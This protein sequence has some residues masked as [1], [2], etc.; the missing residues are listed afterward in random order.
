[1]TTKELDNLITFKMGLPSLYH[2]MLGMS[3]DETA[4]YEQELENRQTDNYDLNDI[5]KKYG[6]KV[7]RTGFSDEYRLSV[8]SVY[9]PLEHIGERELK[10]LFDYFTFRMD[11]VE[12]KFNYTSNADDEICELNI[13]NPHRLI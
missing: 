6:V 11:V 7:E 3:M 12:K 5:L 10:M 4:D 9:I 2:I 1:M 8:I 13:P